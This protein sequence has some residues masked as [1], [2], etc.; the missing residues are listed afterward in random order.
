MPSMA[1]TTRVRMTGRER[2]SRILEVA[3]EGFAARGY[4]GASMSELAAAAGVTKPVL[5]DHF[6]SKRALYV[7]LMESIRDDLTARGAAAMRADAPLE[8][9]FRAAVEAFFVFVE[10]RP[11]AARVLLVAPRGE[12]EL[13][14]PA[15]RVQEGATGAISALLAAEPE[16]L[17]GARDRRRRVELF[18]EFL[19]QGMHGLAEWWAEHP[20]T[21][22]RVL[23]DATMDVAWAGV[24]ASVAARGSA[25]RSG[26]APTR[27]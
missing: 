25:P 3:V 14:E 9:R 7:A 4:D 13:V 27:P 5:Y 21:P 10:D 2:R 12:P 24:R 11:A 22:R 23:V 15:R 1:M 19:K 16:L 18:A 8:A 26:R 20:D 17:R 6:A